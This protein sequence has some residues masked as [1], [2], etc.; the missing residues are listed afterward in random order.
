MKRGDSF[1][2]GLGDEQYRLFHDRRLSHEDGATTWVGALDPDAGLYRAF[3]SYAANGSVVGRIITPSGVYKIEQA[4]GKLWVIDLKNSGLANGSLE[5]DQQHAGQGTG[6]YER[7]HLISAT[8]DRPA[9]VDVMVLYT[10]TVNDNQ[11]ELRV[12]HL[13]ALTRQAFADSRIFVDLRLAHA[14]PL[15]TDDPKSNRDALA[16]LT[17]NRLPLD[18]AGLRQKYGADLV[19]WLRPLQASAQ[20]NCGVAW[21]GGREGTPAGP[22]SGFAVVSDGYDGGQYCH[23]YTFAHE[24]GHLFGNVHDSEIS[25]PG[26]FPF[27]FAWGIP[28]RFATI[29]SYLFDQA[30]LVGKFANLDLA[31]NARTINQ[32]A[33]TIAAFA[34]PPRR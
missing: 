5:G 11:P 3:I 4:D 6:G 30:P 22:E 20:G 26:I 18:V 14:E 10:P 34:E 33:P 8:E 31:D 1:T 32:T 29:M 16:A 24:L 21:I 23:D 15:P 27:S 13:L 9:A 17:E 12:D 2:L 28:G 25:D 7:T 19:L